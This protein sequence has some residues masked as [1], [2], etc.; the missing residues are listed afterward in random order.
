MLGTKQ[1]VKVVAFIGQLSVYVPSFYEGRG[2]YG[3][4]IHS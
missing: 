4:N 2:V 3:I 1:K